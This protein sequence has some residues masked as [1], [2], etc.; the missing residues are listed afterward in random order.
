MA[1][2][3]IRNSPGEARTPVN[4]VDP[5]ELVRKILTE[6]LGRLEFDAVAHDDIQAVLKSADPSSPLVVIFGPSET[7]G[8]V[9]DR[10]KG[11]F[12][13]RP[14]VGAIM[15][16]HDLNTSVLKQALRA[17]LDDVVSADADDSELRDTVARSISRVVSS[18]STPPPSALS[19]SSS[20]QGRVITVCSTKGGTGKSVVATNL[21]TALAKRTTQP[22]V[23]VD[24]DLQFGDVALMLQL[25]PTHTIADAVKAGERL[26]ASFLERLLLTHPSCG[27]MVLAAST[28]AESADLVAAGDLARI[29]GLLRDRCAYV[30]I[31]TPAN[32]SSVT[33]EA[34][35]AAD[36]VLVVSSLDVTSLKSA[37]VGVETMQAMGIP[38]PKMRLVL[39][40]ANTKVGLT[41]RDVERAV[42]L[43]IDTALPS[44]VV[45]AESVNRGIPVV[46]GAPRSRFAR[47]IDDLA[48]RLMTSEPN[49]GSYDRN[50]QGVCDVAF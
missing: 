12:A 10:I 31:D 29:I 23:L 42:R 47:A 5:D 35:D 27:L 37:R 38:T 2:A 16:V 14:G 40:R 4:V 13:F 18:Q 6:H 49:V 34:L 22:V 32:Y 7:P 45:V 44:D 41:E 28:E 20:G 43:G 17:G 3:R 19:V 50:A 1:R 11:L 30:V 36:D 21:A 8:D 46:M 9:I 15:I 48:K 25:Q 33:R 26:D 39:N 24:G